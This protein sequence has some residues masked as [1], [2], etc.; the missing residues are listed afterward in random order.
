MGLQGLEQPSNRLLL[1][2]DAVLMPLH[3][4][5]RWRSRKTSGEGEDVLRILR[6]PTLFR[7]P[8]FPS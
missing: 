3:F 4:P 8:L 2:L 1:V 5:E 7:V 6:G